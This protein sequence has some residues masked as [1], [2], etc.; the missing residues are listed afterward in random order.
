MGFGSEMQGGSARRMASRLS[1][2]A[3]PLVMTSIALNT[4]LAI[5]WE[6]SLRQ[7]FEKPQ[8]VSEAGPLPSANE[9]LQRSRDAYARARTYQDEGSVKVVWAGQGFPSN[10]TF[11]TVFS[12]GTGFLF[13]FTEQPRRV[14]REVLAQAHSRSVVWGSEQQAGHW[15]GFS[16][17]V[18]HDTLACALETSAGVTHRTSLM[19]PAMLL[20]NVVNYQLY[21]KFAGAQVLG[22]ERVDG[23]PS[24]HLVHA[25]EQEAHWWIDRAS[26]MLRRLRVVDRVSANGA[27]TLVAYEPTVDVPI[28]TSALSFVPPPRPWPH[29]NAVAL[30]LPVIVT[31]LFGLTMFTGQGPNAKFVGRQ[32][33]GCLLVSIAVMQV[34]LVL[35][36]RIGFWHVVL[37]FVMPVL[38]G[39]FGLYQLID[40]R[41]EKHKGKL[42]ARS[43]AL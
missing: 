27:E 4:A 2:A 43:M 20:P 5:S 36:S 12:R 9:I 35:Q 18:E 14:V 30:A 11:Q 42:E 19:V 8:P 38:T 31:V 13:D 7:R 25:A 10:Y 39:G 37:G 23:H 32:R 3:F 16:H 41:L 15:H 28:A 34:V 29:W 1:T 21:D 24:Y 22:V 6:P 33:V 26:Y 40:A 17:Q